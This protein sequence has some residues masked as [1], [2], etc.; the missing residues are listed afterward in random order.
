MDRGQVAGQTVKAQGWGGSDRV[1]GCWEAN[2]YWEWVGEQGRTVD[3]GV[4]STGYW[5]TS[6]C[7]GRE[8]GRAPQLS[9]LN[10]TP[11]LP[12]S[13]P[14]ISDP[15][16]FPHPLPQNPHGPPGPGQGLIPSGL[17]IIVKTIIKQ[18]KEEES[19]KRK[20][21]TQPL[22]RMHLLRQGPEGIVGRVLWG[23][24]RSPLF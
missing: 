7:R 10:L 11:C 3:Q 20:E 2:G 12:L 24:V 23:K 4:C 19:K 17:L 9:E 15:H 5:E 6:W 16:C 1:Q 21:N 18:R 22:G 8:V 14:S 13:S